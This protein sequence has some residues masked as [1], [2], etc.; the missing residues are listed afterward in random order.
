M[1]AIVEIC[2]RRNLI[3]IEDCC[4]ALGGQLNRA[5]TGSQVVVAGHDRDRRQFAVWPES[6]IRPGLRT[7][8][9]WFYG[10]CYQAWGLV[11]TRS[12]MEDAPAELSLYATECAGQDQ[13][14]KLR[15]YTLR[16]DGFVSAHA[17]LAGGE[18]VT[19]PLVFRGR[20][21]VVNYSTSAAGSVM[22]TV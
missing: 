4:E 21:M 22:R 2:K 11:E 6:F 19:R 9:T 20:R 8:D 1:D 10:D 13:P 14:A 12:A 16:I 5:D 7:R 15:R 17:P 18:L 3:L